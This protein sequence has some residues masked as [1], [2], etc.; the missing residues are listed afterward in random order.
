MDRIKKIRTMITGDL[1]DGH[2]EKKH[3]EQDE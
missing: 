3:D 1:H 2:D